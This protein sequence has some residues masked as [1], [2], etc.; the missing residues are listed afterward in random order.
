M[1]TSTNSPFYDPKQEN[2]DEFIE[3]FAVQN[4]DAIAKVAEDP[5]KKAQLLVKVLPTNIVTNLQR[6]LKPTKL[7]TAKYDDIIKVLTSQ[8]EEKKSIVGASV[9]FINRKQGSG[10][11][12]E[13]YGRTLNLLANNCKYS[14]C[15][16][17]RMTRDIFVAGIRDSN[18][19]TSLLQ[20]CDK[21]PDI[22]FEEVL[23]KAKVL[24]QLKQDAISIRGNE[25]VHSYK[26]KASTPVKLNEKYVCIRCGTR[27]DHLQSECWA[28]KLICSQCKVK[29]H[30][31]RACRSKNKIKNLQEEE[32][33]GG[34]SASCEESCSTVDVTAHAI[35]QMT[36]TL[37][38]A[39][40]N[41]RAASSL[42]RGASSNSKRVTK[43]N[44][45]VRMDPSPHFCQDINCKCDSFFE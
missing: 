34:N 39:A 11:T 41:Q 32:D 31:K 17:D 26:V 24:E 40:S 5:L 6:R 14:S 1:A 19:L 15:C 10:E 21:T 36:P 27:N 20:E 23:E 2:I 45:N 8:Y 7:S 16:L 18:I 25:Y 13:A 3:R 12:I 38:R 30:I 44:H 37:P 43:F 33:D 9:K 22:K 42:A 29:G 35:G 4:A 28:L